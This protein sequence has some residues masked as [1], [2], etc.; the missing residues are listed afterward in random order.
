MTVDPARAAAILLPLLMFHRIDE[1]VF[2][3]IVYASLVVL[4]SK[5]ICDGLSAS[6]LAG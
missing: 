2:F 4:G 6:S 1:R 5:L 3:R